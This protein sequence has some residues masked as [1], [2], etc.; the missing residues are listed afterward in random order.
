MLC[1]KKMHR[2]YHSA[3]VSIQ[4][5]IEQVCSA[6][7]AFFCNPVP[8]PSDHCFLTSVSVVLSSHLFVLGFCPGSVSNISGS[9]HTLHF[10]QSSHTI[11]KCAANSLL[12]WSAV[13]VAFGSG[14][15][16]RPGFSS[17][18]FSLPFPI[19]NLSPKERSQ[20]SDKLDGSPFSPT[21]VLF[22]TDA[23]QGLNPSAVL[24]FRV[25]EVIPFLF[26]YAPKSALQ[27]SRIQAWL[28]PVSFPSIFMNY[29]I[30]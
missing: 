5:P 8:L 22:F 1:W 16:L 18:T 21:S 17:F 15:H 26:L 28:C 12:F 29:E 10:A 11:Y 13:C 6:W 30:A 23:Q 24:R 7:H 9:T 4:N 2:V 27:R 3:S 19:K 14:N 20:R 25:S